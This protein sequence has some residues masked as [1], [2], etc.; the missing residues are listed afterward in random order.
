MHDALEGVELAGTDLKDEIIMTT[1]PYG[2]RAISEVVSYEH[3][4]LWLVQLFNWVAYD[5]DRLDKFKKELASRFSENLD[6]LSSLVKGGQFIGAIDT[7]DKPIKFPKYIFNIN[8]N[9]PYGHVLPCE[10]RIRINPCE[11]IPFFAGRLDAEMP[12]ENLVDDAKYKIILDKV[13]SFGIHGIELKQIAQ[14]AWSFVDNGMEF[15]VFIDKDVIQIFNRDLS[16]FSSKIIII[17][18]PIC[19]FSLGEN[20]KQL[21]FKLVEEIAKEAINRIGPLYLPM[22]KDL[23]TMPRVIIKSAGTTNKKLLDLVDKE[24]ENS[25]PFALKKD[26]YIEDVMD[27]VVSTLFGTKVTKWLSRRG[28]ESEIFDSIDWKLVESEGAKGLYGTKRNKNITA[29]SALFF[30]EKENYKIPYKIVRG[31]VEELIGRL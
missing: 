29:I 7:S 11:K 24:R 4:E 13:K 3:I 15:L 14:D 25:L 10:I 1:N 16:P 19:K 20:E 9:V 31:W 28:E 21:F 17:I 26:N 27:G 6:G 12:F 5:P 23:E 18:T 8:L 30:F 2:S 22:C